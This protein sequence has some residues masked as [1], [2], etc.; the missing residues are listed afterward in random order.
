MVKGEIELG[1]KKERTERL[2]RLEIPVIVKG[3][4]DSKHTIPVGVDLDLCTLNGRI[5]EKESNSKPY[6][7][8]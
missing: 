1:G 4:S 7:S 5:K 6:F 2:E 8:R 3:E